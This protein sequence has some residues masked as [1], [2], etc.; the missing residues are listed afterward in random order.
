MRGATP[1]VVE[2]VDR[3]IRAH[4]EDALAARGDETVGALLDVL[5]RL[6]P[7]EEYARDLALYMMVETGYHQWSVRHMVRSTMFWALSTAVG[8]LVVMLFGLACSLGLAMIAAGLLGATDYNAAGT[9]LP[10]PLA[11]ITPMAL[12]AIGTALLA[13]LATLVRWFVGQY[14]R[15]ARP[16]TLGGAD[17]EEGWVQRTSRRIL[18]VAASGFAVTVVAGVASGALKASALGWPPKAPDFTGSPL[19]IVGGM[20]LAVL[21]CAPVLG[22]LWTVLAERGKPGTEGGIGA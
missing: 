14:V 4:I 5:D 8:A 12:I 22:L 16:H 15:Q 3:E 6:G 10:R 11:Y 2:E 1:D 9:L 20:G 18:T 13:G 19:A 17:A 7:P 21:L